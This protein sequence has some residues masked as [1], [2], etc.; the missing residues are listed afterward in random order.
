MSLWVSTSSPSNLRTLIQGPGE[1]VDDGPSPDHRLALYL[2][3]FP[4]DLR[5]DSGP[6]RFFSW[7]LDSWTYGPAALTLDLHPHF[8]LILIVLLPGLMHTV[9]KHHAKPLWNSHFRMSNELEL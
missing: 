8:R 4:S 1:S 6:L 5:T 7:P 3:G 9:I 2:L